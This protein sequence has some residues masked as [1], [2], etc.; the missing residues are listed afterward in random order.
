MTRVLRLA[1]TIVG[2]VALAC[3]P[4]AADAQ[5][6]ADQPKATIAGGYSFLRDL[7][8]GATPSADFTNGWFA[9]FTRRLAGP[10]LLVAGEVSSQSRSNL[11]LET[12]RATAMLG[13]VQVPVLALG[14]LVVSGRF[15]AGLERF[16]EPGFNE[17]NVAVQPGV[18]VDVPVPGPLGGRVNADYRL[19]KATGATIKAIQISAGVV[20]ALGGS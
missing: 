14:R 11:G 3:A 2:S 7:G 6:L 19:V 4:A 13:G 8:A 5:G 15:F 18:S 20:I 12:Q 16:A 1:L 17:W 10:R 9:S